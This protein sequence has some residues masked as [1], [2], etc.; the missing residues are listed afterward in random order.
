MTAHKKVNQEKELINLLYIVSAVVL[1]L[2]SFYNLQ[3]IF[4]PKKVLGAKTSA[5]YKSLLEEKSYWEDFL[6]KTPTYH[7]GWLRLSEIEYQLGD[8]KSGKD[9]EDVANRISTNP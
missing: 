7:D 4:N 8:P 3:N 2:F 6:S 9:F 5:E 1:I